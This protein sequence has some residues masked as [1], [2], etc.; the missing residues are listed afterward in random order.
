MTLVVGCS[1]LAADEAGKLRRNNRIFSIQAERTSGWKPAQVLFLVRR[2][3]YYDILISWLI[4]GQKDS[5]SASR[6]RYPYKE[7]RSDGL[8]LAKSTS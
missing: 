4:P 5:Y 1:A 7:L 6:N 8:V 3:F 2:K